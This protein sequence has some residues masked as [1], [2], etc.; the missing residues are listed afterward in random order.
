MAKPDLVLLALAAVAV[1]ATT[2]GALKSDDWT[3]ERTYRFGET[4]QPLPPQEAQPAGSAPARFEVPV[5]PNGTGLRATVQ[6][7]FTGQAVQGGT[8]VVRIGGTGPDGKPLPTLTRTLAIEQGATS[9]G[10]SFAYNATWLDVPGA[11][12]DTR[13]PAGTA[14]ERPLV[15]LVTVERPSDAPLAGY[16]FTAGLAGS[17]TRYASS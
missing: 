2:V 6:V 11:V 13:V 17:F 9:G 1:V 4:Q 8:A 7:D 14:W 12:R 10:A 16:A 5:P 15:L 3:G